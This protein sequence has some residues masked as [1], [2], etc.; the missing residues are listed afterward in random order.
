[1]TVPDDMPLVTGNNTVITVTVETDV[2][3]LAKLK[4]FK[5]EIAQ[6][7]RSHS[8]LYVEPEREDATVAIL[9]ASVVFATMKPDKEPTYVTDL[10]V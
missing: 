10:L 4:R 1:M 2:E 3:S 5:K 6:R 8:Q 7:V 9:K